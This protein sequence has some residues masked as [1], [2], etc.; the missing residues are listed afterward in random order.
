M[1]LETSRDA[2]L[3]RLVSHVTW[4]QSLTPR[5]H[6]VGEALLDSNALL[7]SLPGFGPRSPFW[8]YVLLTIR[9]SSAHG[10]AV[11]Q[12]PRFASH[13]RHRDKSFRMFIFRKLLVVFPLF[14]ASALRSWRYTI[15]A[16]SGSQT[17]ELVGDI[18]PF[19]RKTSGNSDTAAP[20]ARAAPESPRHQAKGTDAASM[21]PTPPPKHS[22]PAV[23][24]NK[25]NRSTK[26]PVATTV[27]HAY[28]L[29]P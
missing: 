28:R 16:C 29:V 5:S 25:G 10:P 19:F 13:C 17:Q 2:T 3:T 12:Q 23:S 11:R 1:S 7:C 18:G 26:L 21:S 22:S 24:P 9:N 8:R 14:F 4:P 27:S 6:D 20:A 15:L